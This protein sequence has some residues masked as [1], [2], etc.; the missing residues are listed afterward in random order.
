M[1]RSIAFL[2]ALL[3]L[4]MGCEGETEGIDEPELLKLPDIESEIVS[5]TDVWEQIDP[6]RTYWSRFGTVE[7]ESLIVALWQAGLPVSRAWQ[8]LDNRCMDPIGPRFTVELP[9]GD[10]RILEHD[11][12][13]GPGRLLCSTTLEQFTVS[14]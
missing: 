11:F 10:E 2:S 5:T 7:P 14:E 1:M 12:D 8:P 13:T 4:A 3:V 6:A 9:K